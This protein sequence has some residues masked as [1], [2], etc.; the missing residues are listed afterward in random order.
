VLVAGLGEHADQQDVAAAL[1]LADAPQGF[2]ILFRVPAPGAHPQLGPAAGDPV[3]QGKGLEDCVGIGQDQRRPQRATVVALN[4][5]G[6]SGTPPQ[7][8]YVLQYDD[9]S[10]LMLDTQGPSP[11]HGGDYSASKVVK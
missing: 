6:I 9:A 11:D 10:T 2:N 1:A 4:G 8:N 3:F 5:I 7:A